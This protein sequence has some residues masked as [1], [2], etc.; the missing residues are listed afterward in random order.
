MAKANS[1][2]H[3]TRLA[4][5][6]RHERDCVERGARRRWGVS[7]LMYRALDRLYNILSLALVVYLL[8]TTAVDPV[9]VILFGVFLIG[10]WEAVERFLYATGKREGDRRGTSG[11]ERGESD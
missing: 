3:S 6:L 5:Q 9:Y 11:T 7:P 1:S 8:E 10:G 4:S 2:S